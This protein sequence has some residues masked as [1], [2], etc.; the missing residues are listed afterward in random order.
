MESVLTAT[1]LVKSYGKVRA[2]DGIDLAVYPKEVYGLLGPNGSG[3]TTTLSMLAGILRPD[4]GQVRVAG[5]PVTHSAARARLGLVPQEIA[6]YPQMTAA[7]NLAFFGRMQGMTGKTLRTRVDEV[8]EIVD[9]TARAKQRV[10]RFSSG[11]KRRV[12]IAVALVHSPDLLI[13]D[14]PTVGV[15]PQSRNAILDQVNALAAA[16]TAVIFASHY[17]EEVQRLCN[18]I[19][20]IDAGKI[21][22][23][24]T[25]RELLSDS[26]SRT[27]IVLTVAAGEEERL[28]SLVQ[29]LP[30]DAEVQGS[31]QE[32]HLLASKP[33]ELLTPLLRAAEAAGVLLQGVQLIQ[34]SLE[35]VF[36]ELTGKALRE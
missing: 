20:I 35:D 26:P 18:R 4:S 19:A 33:A 7:E 31:G 14:E 27:R 28:H 11:M 8:L 9:L 13:M 32:L 17:M 10:E 6:L 36:L 23:T 30:G 21:L 25:V 2:V 16:G 12:N 15:D 24:G 29:D 5:I 34:P 1:G 22:A 3:K